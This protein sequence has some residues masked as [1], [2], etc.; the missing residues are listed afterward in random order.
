MEDG[1]GW[2]THPPIHG[3]AASVTQMV[4]GSQR[5]TGDMSL[6]SVKHQVYGK[7]TTSE[8]GRHRGHAREPDTQDE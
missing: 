1:D 4:E 2:M 5:G 3:Q 7:E 6:L 8:K